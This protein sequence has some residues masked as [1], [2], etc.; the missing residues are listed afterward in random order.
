MDARQRARQRMQLV[1]I[2]ALTL[3]VFVL[4]S[5]GCGE[6]IRVDPVKLRRPTWITPMD[7]QVERGEN[8]AG[9]PALV[10]SPPEAFVETQI[11]L[12]QHIAELHAAPFW[13]GEKPVWLREES[14]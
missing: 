10:I 9:E 6:A 8:S 2:V 7:F 14:P 3:A 11:R 12:Q 1:L 4:L 13:D 5:A